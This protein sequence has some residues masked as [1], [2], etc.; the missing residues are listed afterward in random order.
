LG[1]LAIGT[2]G[3]PKRATHSGAS[4][5]DRGVLG[6]CRIY[7]LFDLTDGCFCVG[8]VVGKGISKSVDGTGEYKNGVEGLPV[9]GAPVDF[10]IC[11][12]LILLEQ[13]ESNVVRRHE[14]LGLNG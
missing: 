7:D 5:L 14:A 6:S 4:L 3:A 1:A 8:K 11:S 2:S 12:L 10:C 9:N 13:L